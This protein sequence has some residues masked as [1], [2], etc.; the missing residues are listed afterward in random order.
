MVLKGKKPD[1]TKHHHLIIMK[2]SSRS[3][4]LRC[5]SS[6]CGFAPPGGRL[7]GRC[8]VQRH[9]SMHIHRSP[10]SRSPEWIF[11][12]FPTNHLEQVYAVSTSPPGWG[13][14]KSR[15]I[16]CEHSECEISKRMWFKHNEGKAAAIL[17][18]EYTIPADLI[19]ITVGHSSS[20]DAAMLNLKEPMLLRR[21]NAVLGGLAA[22][23]QLSCSCWFFCGKY[24]CS[25][26]AQ[27][28]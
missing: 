13:H 10:H 17:Y 25:F 18:V 24:T 11:P 21:R 15:T 4:D 14:T 6:S 26:Q 1:E 7:R 3:M 27:N 20:S 22:A 2:I 19:C 8:S 16:S 28:L 23:E 9:A 12:S 5:Q